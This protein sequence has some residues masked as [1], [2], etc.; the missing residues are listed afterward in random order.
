[1]KK[2]FSLLVLIVAIVTGAWADVTVYVQAETAPYLYA[3]DGAGG[4]PNGE[5]PGKQMTESAVVKETT[6]WKKTFETSGFNIIFSSGDKTPQTPDITGITSDRYFTFD[7]TDGT[8]V[9]VTEQY[10][11]LPDATISS[12]KL[13]GDHNGWNGEDFT[14]V[15]AGAEYTTTVDLTGQT[16]DDGKWLF[17]FIVNGGIWFGFSNVTFDGGQPTWVG[18]GPTDSRAR[19]SP[20]QLHGVVESML[21]RIGQ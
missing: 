17:K 9:D 21:I 6:F 10:G 3:W 1:M 18:Q 20:S 12:L 11:E 7:A 19:Y 8:Y 15:T 14:V 4:K 16:Y 5:W 2:L 13:A